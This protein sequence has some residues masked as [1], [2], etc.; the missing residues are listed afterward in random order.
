[1]TATATHPRRLPARYRPLVLLLAAQLV[2]GVLLGLV[3]LVWSP[4]SVAYNV[5]LGS[6]KGV[7]V[8]GE[9]ESLVAADGRFV[10][11]TAAAGLIFGLAAWRLRE[12]RGRLPLIA[13]TVVSL[14]ASV[15][16]K[17]TGQLLSGGQHSA[18]INTAFRA[19]L[20]LH[21]NA[22][23]LVQALAAALVYTV[24]VGL[25]GDA[26]LGRTDVCTEFGP[27]T[28]AGE[29]EDGPVATT[30]HGPLEP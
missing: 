29:Y 21:A 18:P 6:G 1:M 10:V 28:A 4:H 23:L 7:I 17:Y 30:G 24:L 9:G 12:L 27:A 20:A 3:W 16:A 11:L 26:E 15:L 22:A 2:V 14:V 13:L 5:D 19:Q 8:P 25:T